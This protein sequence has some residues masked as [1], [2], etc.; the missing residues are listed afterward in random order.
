MKNFEIIEIGRF[1]D[2]NNL[3]SISGGGTELCSET[4]YSNCSPFQ[5]LCYINRTCEQAYEIQ[6]CFGERQYS[7]KEYYVACYKQHAFCLPNM[8]YVSPCPSKKLFD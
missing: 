4:Q 2:D 6:P 7:C 1:L 3:V 8:T 5:G